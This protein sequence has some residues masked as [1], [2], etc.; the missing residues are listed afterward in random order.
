VLRAARVSAAILQDAAK[1]PLL[2][3]EPNCV[4]PADDVVMYCSDVILRCPPSLAGLE[5]WPQAQ[6]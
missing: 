3:G 5:G 2:T 1:R 6:R 4:H